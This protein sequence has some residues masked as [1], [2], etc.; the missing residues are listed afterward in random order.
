MSSISRARSPASANVDA[1]P[2]TT[3]GERTGTL[4]P[5]RDEFRKCQPAIQ[6]GQP[7]RDVEW[8][9]SA[10]RIGFA[11][12]RQ[13]VLV[14][15]AERDDARQDRG[16]GVQFVEK[17]FTRQPHRAPGRQIE[18]CVGEPR[19]IAAG[20]EALDQPAVD[21]R[22]DHGAQERDGDGN[23]E[24]AHGLPDS[25]SRANIVRDCRCCEPGKKDAVYGAIIFPAARGT[26]ELMSSGPS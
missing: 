1:G 9:R 14:D 7:W 8:L 18:R 11:R 5:G 15:V 3:S 6:F 12:E 13:L 17:H 25:E 22:G 23:S 20:L 16:I 24:D 2:P 19:W 10:E 26:P 4:G 21:Q